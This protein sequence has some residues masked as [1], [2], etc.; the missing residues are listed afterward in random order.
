MHRVLHIQSTPSH[1]KEKQQAVENNK[2]KVIAATFQ[3]WMI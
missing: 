2:A 1:D 3:C